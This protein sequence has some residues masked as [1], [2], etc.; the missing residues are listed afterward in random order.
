MV[1]FMQPVSG[2]RRVPGAGP[3]DAKI[4]IVGEA[5]GSFEV[6]QLKPFVGPAGSVLE[7]CLHAAGLIRSE[8]YLTNVVKVMPKGNDI[9]PYFN[10]LRGTF[11]EEGMKW[12]TELYDEIN[13]LEPNIVV[14]CGAVASAA[15]T[16]QHKILKYRGYLF[17]AIGLAKVQKVLPTIHPSA[18]L[19]GQYTYRHL[20][21]ADLK[22]AKHEST[23]PELNRPERQLVYRFD[24]VGEVLEWLKYFE[25]APVVSFDIE[26]LN[27][28]LACIAFSCSPDLS[29]SIPLAGTWSIEDE[30]L[31]WLGIQRVLGNERSVKVGQNLIF[32]IQFLLTR[33][34]IEV[35]GPI[36]DTMV[37]HSIMYPELLKGLGFLGSLYCGA[38]AYWKDGV[39]FTNI[40]EES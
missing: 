38:Q 10:G 14:A 27:Y 20:I 23:F 30:A 32:D 21:A 12:V 37:A 4:V 39:K 1:S 15:L 19:R 35:R 29:C 26:V 8:V 40:K 5:P 2:P 3:R 7:T 22:K 24:S 34:G 6:A 36:H 9:A 31:I 18:S 16:G 33:C 11:S 13:E 28:E 25:D 17:D